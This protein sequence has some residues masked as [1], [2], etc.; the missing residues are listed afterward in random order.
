MHSFWK[1]NA[2]TN[3]VE[4]T[5]SLNY[6]SNVLVQHAFVYTRIQVSISDLKAFSVLLCSGR[7]SLR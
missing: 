6:P 1:N 3:L 2:G 5:S 4:V 7:K